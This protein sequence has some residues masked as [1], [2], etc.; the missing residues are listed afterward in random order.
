MSETPVL[1]TNALCEDENPI[2]VILLHS[3]NSQLRDFIYKLNYS[4]KA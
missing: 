1:L 2:H 3:N 4:M